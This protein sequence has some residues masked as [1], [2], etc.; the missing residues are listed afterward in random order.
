M[1]YAIDRYSIGTE[2]EVNADDFNDQ[3]YIPNHKQRFFCPECN[4]I[5]FFRAKGGKKPNQF[6]H[7]KRTDRTPECDRRVDGRSN[8]SISQRVGL[9]IFITQISSGN[10]QLSIGFP[11]LGIKILENAAKLKCILNISSQDKHRT[12]KIDQTNFLSDNTTLIPVDFIPLHGMN[13]SISISSGTQIFDLQ[14][15]WSD[16]ADGFELNGAIFSY[17]ETGGKKIRRGDSISTNRYYYAVIKNDFLFHPQIIQTE[18]G[19]LVINNASYKV[20]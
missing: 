12:I 13:Y 9:P 4:E 5:V 10:F 19:K 3:Y 14:R 11:A 8:L 7:Q 17:S 1:K 2:V 20:R 16:Y 15:K 6:F 18:I